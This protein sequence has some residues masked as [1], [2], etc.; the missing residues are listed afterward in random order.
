MSGMV[1]DVGDSGFVKFSARSFAG[2]HRGTKKL[3]SRDYEG[4]GLVD[5]LSPTQYLV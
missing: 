5:N 4:I 3:G 2:H 1:A